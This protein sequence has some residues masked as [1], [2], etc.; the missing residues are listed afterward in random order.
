VLNA[1]LE[2]KFKLSLAFLE[3]PG[4]EDES[5]KGEKAAEPTA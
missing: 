3:L 4:L 2:I 1:I 5:K